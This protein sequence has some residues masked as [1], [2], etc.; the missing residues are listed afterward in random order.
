MENVAVSVQNVGTFLPNYTAS[1][2]GEQQFVFGAPFL[3]L[4]KIFVFSV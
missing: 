2:L 1:Y 3:V 4:N